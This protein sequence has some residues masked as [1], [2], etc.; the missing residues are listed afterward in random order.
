MPTPD[1]VRVIE[2]IGE[3]KTDIG[4]GNDGPEVPTRG[5]VPILVHRLCDR[6]DSMRVRRR[7][8]T[9][10]QGKG[11]RQKVAFAKRQAY[12][13]RSAGVVFV[14][15]TE[16]VHPGQR[17]ELE[18]GRD[19][20][21]SDF[22]AAVGVAHPCIEAWLLSD[23]SAIERAILPAQP[24]EV[25]DDPESLPAPCKDRDRNPKAVLGRCAGRDRALSAEQT[26]LIAR[27]IRDLEP[28]RARCRLGFA[29]FADEVI[30]RIR[31][32]FEVGDQSQQ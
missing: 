16:G 28:I 27:E 1:S 7:P 21:L 12:Y 15:D 9:F 5:V 20:E 30:G 13:N 25:P 32:I 2:I 22:P 11:L 29:P 4:R 19:R 14:V 3:G 17:K 26:S 23:P 6:P 10:L 24:I 18:R 8:L 31:P